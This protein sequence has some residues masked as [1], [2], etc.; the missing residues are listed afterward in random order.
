MK[1]DDIYVHADLHGASSVIVKNTST[2]QIPPTTLFQA[3]FMS[4]VQSKA[5]DSKIVTSAWWVNASQVSKTAPSGEYLTQGSFMIRGKKNWLPPVNLVY[6]FGLFFRVEESCIGRHYYER[7]PWAR[8][9]ESMEQTLSLQ[10]EP[11]SDEY[12]ASLED[13]NIN[14]T[15]GHSKEP[16]KPLGEIDENSMKLSIEDSP[17]N[18]SESSDDDEFPDTVIEVD[19]PDKYGLSGINESQNETIDDSAPHRPPQSNGARHLSAKQRRDLKKKGTLTE[20]S[21]DSLASSERSSKTDEPGKKAIPRG[22]KGKMKKMKE[23]YAEQDEEEREM[24]V[25]FLG[26]AQ[27]PQPKGK[28]AKAQAARKLQLEELHKER[29]KR[30]SEA[31]HLKPSPKTSKNESLEIQ[32]IL[33]EENIALPDD[34]LSD[35]TY[36]DSLTGQPHQD[37]ILLFAI[38]VCAPWNA[39]QKFKYKVKLTPGSLKKGKAA[40][41]ALSTF[42]AVASGPEGREKE[43][44]LIKSIQENDLITQ[45]LGKVKISGQQ[46]KKGKK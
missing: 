1:K 6:G 4:V 5:W 33:D 32:Q 18:S 42:I 28:K 43:L 8:S 19:N 2:D 23:K 37:D 24:I 12:S 10:H 27:G 29:E 31:E 34:D 25:K 35:L 26:S 3:G 39:L 30:R 36:L 46:S 44:E 7:R 45:M 22:K 40:K 21:M 38:P 17:A 9:E 13:L 14:E 16:A 11:N 15:I 20:S 41:S